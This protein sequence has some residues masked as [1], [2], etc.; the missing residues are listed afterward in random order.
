M[1]NAQAESIVI[2]EEFVEL[3]HLTLPSRGRITANASLDLPTIGVA[4]AVY[5][6][7]FVLTWFFQRIS[8]WVA[9]PVGAVLL[10]WHGS[11]QHE[12]I[13]NHPTQSRR[14]NSWLAA[15]PLALWLP[16]R[17]YRA[18]HLKHHR[19]GGRHLSK[20]SNDPE[21]FFLRSGTLARSG[22]FRR[23]LY[24]IHCTLVGRLILG[25]AFS[26]VRLWKAE[27]RRVLG[28]DRPRRIIWARHGLG[29]AMVLL[30]TAAVCHIPIWAYLMFVVYP[31][32]SLSHLRS[33]TEHRA[34][35][36]PSLR[37]MTVE[38]HPVWALIFL[39]N[40]LHIAH[41]AH[42][43]LPWHQLPR[44]WRQMRA[45]A[46][47]AGLVF[48]RGYLQVAGKYLFRPVISVEHPD[49]DATVDVSM[50]HQTRNR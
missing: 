30:W 13:H 12:T 16:Y 2:P 27:A 48:S 34:D 28:G 41:H 21:S 25:P 18:T 39:N 33:F 14:V 38:A 4:I 26:I 24:L 40:N 44:A 19:H 9:A 47:A 23:A 11:L 43:E 45:C 20:V 31:S 15:P 32:V 50:S 22:W 3:G 29:V 10:A 5:A 1:N 49:H 42:P 8:I 36:D 37:T 17:I 46:D 7:Y 6:G 35:S